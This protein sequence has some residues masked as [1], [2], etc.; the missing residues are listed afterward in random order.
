[1]SSP[2]HR[3]EFVRVTLRAACAADPLRFF[4]A[5]ASPERCRILAGIW[6]Q[7]E[8]TLGT[9]VPEFDR[10]QTF[11]TTAVLRDRP[12]VLLTLP[13]PRSDDEAY[14]AAL[15]LTGLP[16]RDASA[17]AVDFRCFSLERSATD[18]GRLCEWT[19]AGWIRLDAGIATSLDVFQAAIEV[20][21]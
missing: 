17:D 16:A 15:V 19:D 12:V 14:F 21:L 5:M 9:P 8:R 11:A 2:T 10:A 4:A 20:R 6:Q 3:I 18:A 13:A 7:V 1:M